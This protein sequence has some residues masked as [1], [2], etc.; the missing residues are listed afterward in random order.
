MEF[1]LFLLQVFQISLWPLLD[2]TRQC[3]FFHL[4][5]RSDKLQLPQ[6]RESR[7]WVAPAE[8]RKPG[9]WFWVAARRLSWSE[10]QDTGASAPVKRD[11]PTSPLPLR[12][13]EM[14]PHSEVWGKPPPFSGKH[15]RLFPMLIPRLLLFE[16]R[17]RTHPSSRTSVRLSKSLRRRVSAVEGSL[18]QMRSVLFV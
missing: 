9:P 18:S 4:W 6:N 15:H 3:P 13:W 16:G 11:R 17:G 2:I 1:S 10:P 7:F 5:P 12:I 8:V 14:L